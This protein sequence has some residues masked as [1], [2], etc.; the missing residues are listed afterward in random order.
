MEAI[1]PRG[2]R[3]LSQVPRLPMN[4]IENVVQTFKTLSAIYNASM[5]DLQAVEG[6]GE[7]RAAMIKEE[8]VRLKLQ[9]PIRGHAVPPAEFSQTSS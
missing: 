4:I 2:Y 9:Q 7:V 3:L 5:E 8:L 1:E 6:V